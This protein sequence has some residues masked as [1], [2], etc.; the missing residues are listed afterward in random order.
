M[1]R[2]ERIAIGSIVCLVA[3]I[4]SYVAGSKS[5]IPSGLPKPPAI[6]SGKFADEETI[7]LI[8]VQKDNVIRRML[9]PGKG[10]GSKSTESSRYILWPL[11]EITKT[12]DTLRK[13][14]IE[15]QIKFD[16]PD[17]LV[18]EFRWNGSNG[19]PRKPRMVM[20]GGE[21]LD[22]SDGYSPSNSSLR[23]PSSAEMIK[24]TKQ[25]HK[26][27]DIIVQIQDGTGGWASGSGPV[28]V[29]GNP[30]TSC[31]A[32]FPAWIRSE[33]DLKIRFVR[34]GMPPLEFTVPNPDVHSPV[35]F[36][37][38]TGG[39]PSSFTHPEFEVRLEE[40][41]Q[42]RKEDHFPFLKPEFRFRRTPGFEM[43][44]QWTTQ[45]AEDELGNKVTMG[46]YGYP[47]PDVGSQ[48]R[49]NGLAEY[50][51]W[52]PR[53]LSE[54]IPICDG[55]IKPDG[56]L[57]STNLIVGN[58]PRVRT[59]KCAAL[60]TSETES[61]LRFAAPRDE[62]SG[63]FSKAPGD[64]SIPLLGYSIELSGECASAEFSAMERQLGKMS[65][66]QIL[67]FKNGEERSCSARFFSG[68]A[69]STE[70]GN[71]SYKL[72]ENCVARLKPG[73]TVKVCLARK[74]D[75]VPVSLTFPKSEIKPEF[76]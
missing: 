26:A 24:A 57:L 66:W 6:Q 8:D 50:T 70:I 18:A 16:A 52:H 65:D 61:V 31:F 12:T 60:P 67:L 29:E 5:S 25:L 41:W 17:P 13:H 33:K 23:C 73:D 45:S 71:H 43:Y 68:S 38:T 69:N 46:S 76:R 14:L 22:F 36:A 55:N 4:I 35:P 32:V 21:L 19:E 62:S 54:C 53:E 27:P 42:L 1:Q 44:W 28:W 10:I 59:V 7:E 30:H 49:F 9:T 56:S 64:P 11:V 40:V 75:P 51:E 58:I 39:I 20:A 63:D 74:K 37:V 2:T 15:Y 72:E 47:L 48:V 34:S 3:G